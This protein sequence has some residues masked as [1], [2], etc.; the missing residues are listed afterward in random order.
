MNIKLKLRLGVGLLF[1]F[2]I[3]LFGLGA[4]NIIALNRDTQNILVANYNTLDYSREMIKALDKDMSEL[5]TQNVFA[6]NLLCQQQNITEPGEQELTDKLIMDFDQL[7]K[8]PHELNIS[9]EIRKDLTDIMLINMKAIQHKSNVAK[10]TASEAIWWISI[11][12]AF[13][14]IIAFSLLINLPS[15]IANPIR[16][17]TD[18]IQ[19]IADRNYSERVNF[20][21]HSE[22]GQLATAFNTMATKLEEYKNSTLSRL[23]FEKKRFEILVNKM[24]D[25]L[26]G[27]NE[28]SEILFVNE[29]ALKILNIA[30][31]ELIGIKAQDIALKNDLMRTLIQDII[32]PGE[33]KSNI[34]PLKIFAD[35]K[36]SYFEKEVI[37]INVTPTGEKEAKPE[38]YFILLRNITSYK[39]LDFA[40]TNFIATISHEL[41]TPIS[42]I[43]AS[44]HLLQ[45]PLTGSLNADQNQLIDSIN[46]DGLRLL[47]ITS[48]LLH[49]SQA[50]S[51]NIQLS[52]YPC[53]P[54]LIV[55]YALDAVQFMAEQKGVSINFANKI[56]SIDILA[57]AE[58]TTWVLINF[59]TNAIRYTSKG[60]IVTI[61]TK[62]VDDNSVR[63]SVS[64]NGPGIDTKYIGKLFTRYFQVPEG[65]K[66]GT[67]LGLAI[68]KEFIEA[69]A[70]IIGVES[71]LGKGSTFYFS[72]PIINSTASDTTVGL[73]FKP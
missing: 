59:L 20:E 63:F 23:M 62:L 3:L 72:L 12:G 66:S 10:K 57:D 65:N 15:S 41:K 31:N 53:S 5:E 14:F 9:S 7:K 52:I 19:Q 17:L 6:K 44:V 36:E 30:E 33:S 1:V 32:F 42:S 38:G 67:G 47:K 43:K 35:A 56:A 48:E 25:P 50:E 61:D 51:G 60:G 68:S 27:L 4:Y 39:E 37:R 8:Y 34:R 2:I 49:L 29:A 46:D 54:L 64:D 22:F 28:Q 55:K 45:N 71:C 70:G 40:K 18:S 58:K 26:I 73:C 13:C 11:V 24:H 16:E 21:Q 69:Q